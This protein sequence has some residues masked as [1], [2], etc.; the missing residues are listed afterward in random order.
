LQS[1][2]DLTLLRRFASGTEL[3]PGDTLWEAMR[4]VG[5]DL[6]AYLRNLRERLD[7]IS[8][9]AEFW[10]IAHAGGSFRVLAMPRTDPLPDEP[11]AGLGRFIMGL[12]ESD[13]PIAG[14]VYPDRRGSGF[15]LSRHNDHPNLDF[16]RIQDEADVHFAHAR[17]FVAKTSAADP[18][19][20]KAL[21]AQAWV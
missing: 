8:R 17:G 4:W 5:E 9:N 13:A 10:D 20:L 21:L 6:L 16:T 2:V 15:A 14:L 1:P 18:G 7:Y 19:R 11:S 3:K 12:P